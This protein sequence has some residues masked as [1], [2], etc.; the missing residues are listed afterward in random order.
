MVI[1]LL[2][3]SVVSIDPSINHVLELDNCHWLVSNEVLVKEFVLETIVEVID[4]IPIRDVHQIRATF[5]KAL[6]VVMCGFTVFL[7]A[8]LEIMMICW[9]RPFAL[10]IIHDILGEHEPVVDRSFGELFKQS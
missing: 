3:Y 8:I 1:E 2:S 4:H 10:E 9:T 7:L 6:V 5:S